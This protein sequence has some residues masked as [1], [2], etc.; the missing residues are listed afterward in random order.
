MRFACLSQACAP[1]C[2]S[3]MFFSL[4]ATQVHSAVGVQRAGGERSRTDV[5]QTVHL[6]CARVRLRSSR[7]LCTQ[8]QPLFASQGGAASTTYGFRARAT[9]FTRCSDRQPAATLAA[10]VHILTLASRVLG[11]LL[12]CYGGGQTSTP[13]HWTVCGCRL[14][15]PETGQARG[16]VVV[17]CTRLC[18]ALKNCLRCE[19]NFHAGKEIQGVAGPLRGSEV[20]EVCAPPD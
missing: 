4:L 17:R 8:R 19:G 12:R 3:T 5:S 16:R 9:G 15:Y 11:P 7:V 13:G 6:G 1:L 2:G 18:A 10:G 20:V 14:G